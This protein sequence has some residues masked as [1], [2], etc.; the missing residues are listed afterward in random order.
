[1]RASSMATY[2]R[3]NFT[4]TFGSVTLLLLAML[5]AGCY[6]PTIDG[7]TTTIVTPAWFIGATFAL[8]F[9][10]LGYSAWN[11]KDDPRHFKYYIPGAIGLFIVTIPG[12]DMLI[13]KAVFDNK[14]FEIRTGDWWAPRTYAAEFANMISIHVKHTDSV[15]RGR[16]SEAEKDEVTIGL[17]TGQMVFTLAKHSEHVNELCSRARALGIYVSLK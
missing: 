8:G 1:M 7:E 10:L 9:S 5:V 12:P 17:K 4:R 6:V 14:H 16:R 13:E 11:V 2:V 3:A 15:R